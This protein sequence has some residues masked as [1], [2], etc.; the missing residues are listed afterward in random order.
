MISNLTTS[1]SV[2]LPHSHS[3]PLQ[4]R[5]RRHH[6]QTSYADRQQAP[7]AVRALRSGHHARVHP[8][9]PRSLLREPI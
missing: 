7:L 6:A 9:T 4:R 2:S 5:T 8:Q 1:P 3:F